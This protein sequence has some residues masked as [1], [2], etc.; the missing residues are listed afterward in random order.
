MSELNINGS[1]AYFP[2]ISQVPGAIGTIIA[3]LERY[4]SQPASASLEGAAT[5]S[6]SEA[7][8]AA[9]V[10]SAG[11]G[12]GTGPPTPVK[13]DKLTRAA[14]REDCVIKILRLVANLAIHP[15]V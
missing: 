9:A 6:T 8:S 1:Y 2:Q 13:A 10:G 15:E 14:H 12:T 7:S 3:I 4:A 5:E 11:T